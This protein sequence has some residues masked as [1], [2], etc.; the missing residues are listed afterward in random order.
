MWCAY[1]RSRLRLGLEAMACPDAPWHAGPMQFWD[2]VGSIAEAGLLPLVGVYVG[3]RLSRSDARGDRLYEKRSELYVDLLAEAARTREHWSSEQGP[4][5]DD[6]TFKRLVARTVAF[7][8]TAVSEKW[9][10]FRTQSG[11]MLQHRVTLASYERNHPGEA[12]PQQFA[13]YLT[14][15][16]EAQTK[17]EAAFHA[18]EDLINE[19]L[20][21]G[22]GP[23]P[24]TRRLAALW[25]H[26][27]GSG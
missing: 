22:G 27:T 11:F 16:T 3:A 19:E 26:G 24:L 4:A 25:H 20:S 12:L 1:P 14:A 17:S 7:A 13:A 9:H 5:P 6:A 10:E 23:R 8:S 18:L 15:R 21:M 2:Q